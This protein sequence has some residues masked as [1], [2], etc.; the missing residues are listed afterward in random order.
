[1]NQRLNP[2]ILHASIQIK[3]KWAVIDD[4]NRRRRLILIVF[5]RSK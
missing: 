4:G 1:M 2:T 5:L 3:T